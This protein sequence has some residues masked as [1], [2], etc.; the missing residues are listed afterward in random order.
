MAAERVPAGAPVHDGLGLGLA[1][2][3]ARV[4]ILEL[5]AVI[6]LVSIHT[7][8][9]PR[10]VREVAVEIVAVEVGADA[11]L[12]AV[13]VHRGDDK[14]AGRVNDV[15]DAVIS[16]IVLEEVDDEVDEHLAANSYERV[17]LERNTS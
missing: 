6:I 5:V 4:R 16:T 15:G 10:G 17:S 11:A 8:I 12:K 2:I 9:A 7:F 13:G 14:D 1:A 3:R